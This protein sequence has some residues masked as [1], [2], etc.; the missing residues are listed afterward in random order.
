MVEADLWGNE[1]NK[2]KAKGTLLIIIIISLIFGGC[3]MNRIKEEPEIIEL[4]ESSDG[5]PVSLEIKK[6]QNWS[7]RMQ[8][9][10]FI[11]NIL[12]QIVVWTEDTQG[13]LIETLYI[14]GADGKKFRHAAKKDKGALFYEECFPVWSRKVKEAGGTLPGATNPYPDSVTSATPD[15]GFTLNTKLNTTQGGFTIFMEI[16]QSNDYNASFTRE[17]SDWDGQP[18]LIY[19]TEIP[20]AEKGSRYLMKAIGCG[21]RPG[22]EPELQTDLSE[23]DTAL[24]QV[25]EVIILF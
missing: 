17:N 23:I 8:A 21:G 13:N 1:M 14:T 19:R 2:R 9:G 6:G 22:E 11:F 24:G 5:V 18:S 3:V 25:D 4:R 12:P 15:S 10:P 20:T 7:T 16:N